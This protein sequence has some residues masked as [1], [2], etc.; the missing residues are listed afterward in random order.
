M[1]TNQMFPGYCS[2][3]FT[4]T[5]PF[6]SCP[7]VCLSTTCLSVCMYVCCL[8]C[9]KCRSIVIGKARIFLIVDLQDY[10]FR[11]RVG[12]RGEKLK[13]TTGHSAGHLQRFFSFFNISRTN[14]KTSKVNQQVNIKSLNI[15]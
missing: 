3:S 9:H 1:N 4:Y 7:S 14:S 11:F 10:F 2:F 15:S 12:R 6:F 5:F 8:Y 13:M